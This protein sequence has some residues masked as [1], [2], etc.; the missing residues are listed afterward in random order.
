LKLTRRNILASFFS[1]FGLLILWSVSSPIGSGVDT[2]Y[3]LVST[4]CANGPREDI[5]VNPRVSESPGYSGKMATVPYMFQ[6]CD[7]RN[8]YFWPKCEIE[9][10]HP[11][12]QELRMA[13]PS[14]LS[15]YYRIMNVFA[16]SD[17]IRSVLAIRI[18]NSLIAGIVFLMGM[19]FC[20][21]R[22][23]FALLAAVTF[24]IIP[25]GIQQLSG[26][27]PRSWA[28]LGVMTSW[29]FLYSFLST[30]RE[31][32]LT[33]RFQLASFIFTVLLTFFSRLDASVMVVVTSLFVLIG[34]RANSNLT[35]KRKVISFSV[36]IG[37][38]ILIMR[39]FSRTS[40][41]LSLD[42]PAENSKL[43]YFVFSIIHIP[44]FVTD[45]WGYRVGQQGNGP[46]IVGIIGLSLFVISMAL[47]LQKSDLR[48]RIIASSFSITIFA[49]LAR[50]T[51]STG[52]LVP[53][54]GAYTHGLVAPWLGLVIIFSKSKLQLMSTLG[55]RRIVILLLSFAHAISFYS[56]MEF[57]TKRGKGVGFYENLS[58][59]GTWWWDTW[60]SPNVVFIAGATLLPIFLTLAW[61]SIPLELEESPELR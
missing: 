55:N 40:P 33:R 6:M 36:L 28:M 60:V 42:I 4:W 14:N 19:M 38:T 21:K 12:F 48:Q 17:V 50:S 34:Y 27:N 37:S 58:L 5:C 41:W 30:P 11:E 20:T 23:K 57:F 22:V 32:K 43:Q 8:I 3:H 51:L 53:L 56:W 16:S 13:M 18:M 2:D 10:T 9:Q 29:A 7:D 49:L 59:N 54:P 47:A 45:W 15:A 31:Q 52:S 44:E 46:G 24:S 39:S 25:T 1:F 26:V 61:R 35:S